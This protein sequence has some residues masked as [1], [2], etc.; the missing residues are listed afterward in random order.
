MEWINVKDRLPTE[1]EEVLISSNGFCYVTYH[2]GEG[3]ELGEFNLCDA[4]ITHWQ[5]LP[6]TPII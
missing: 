5:P 3:W 4:E 6:V 2:H 1:D